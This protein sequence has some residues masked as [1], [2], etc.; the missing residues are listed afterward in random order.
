MSKKK[1]FRQWID[2][3]DEFDESENWGNDRRHENIGKRY[4]K[5]KRDI[6]EA[7]RRKQW[8]HDHFDED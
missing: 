6:R 2:E 3:N 7:R 5:G 1:K 8:Q 4:N